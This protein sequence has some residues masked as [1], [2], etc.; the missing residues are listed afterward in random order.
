[1]YPDVVRA[2]SWTAVMLLVAVVAP[3]PA[4]A[5]GGPSSAP[6]APADGALFGAA[7]APGPKQAPY[8]PV[9]D[10]ER[11][12]GRRLAIDRYDLPSRTR[13][14]FPEGQPRDDVWV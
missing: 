11:K 14:Q 10:L 9:T 5:G 6:L 3:S 12:L 13:R 7:V 8:Q 2:R 1:A 4:G